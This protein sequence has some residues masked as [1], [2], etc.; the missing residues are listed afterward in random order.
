MGPLIPIAPIPY[1]RI[2]G[3][4]E[5]KLTNI[6]QGHVGAGIHKFNRNLFGKNSSALIL[7]INKLPSSYFPSRTW[8][9]FQD[10]PG[11]ENDF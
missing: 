7:L 9:Q 4:K 2:C 8:M 5:N 10:F 3:A 1:I 6:L 11:L